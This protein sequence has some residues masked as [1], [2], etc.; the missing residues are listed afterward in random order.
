MMDEFQASNFS[1]MAVDDN[2]VNRLLIKKVLVKGGYNY[3]IF[4]SGKDILLSLKKHQPDLILMDL[5]MPE[6]DGLEVCSQIKSNPKLKDIPIIFITASD[7]KDNVLQAFNLGAV[8]YITKPFHHQELLARIKTH[9][10]LKRTRDELT[11]TLKKLK[12]LATTDSLTGI[13]NRR[14]FLD[15]TE[16]E[17]NLAKRKKRFFSILIID[18]DFFKKINDDYGHFVGDKAIKFLTNNIIQIV[19]KEDFVAR[20]GGEEFVVFL[21]DMYGEVAFGIAERIRSKV[22]KTFLNIDKETIHM[23]VSIGGSYFDEK[24]KS[25]EDVLKR[26]DKG[27]YEAKNSGRNKIVFC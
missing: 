9:L 13:P 2:P 10:D 3:T 6:L 4:D 21:S 5:M 8:D 18:I 15:L 27:L 17:F 22:E 19:R 16:R 11:K 24:D 23:T 12:K 25:I 7:E 20:W 1:V 26:A 14:Y